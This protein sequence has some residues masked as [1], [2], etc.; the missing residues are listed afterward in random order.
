MRIYP[1]KCLRCL[2]IWSTHKYAITFILSKSGWR[3]QFQVT[4]TIL[5][6]GCS[7]PGLLSSLSYQVWIHGPCFLKLEPST[8]SN[9]VPSCSFSPKKIPVPGKFQLSAHAALSCWK[10]S[11]KSVPWHHS[12]FELQ[13]P[14]SLWPGPSPTSLGQRCADRRP[15]ESAVSLHVIWPSLPDTADL[16][17]LGFQGTVPSVCLPSLCGPL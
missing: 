4:N 15:S 14:F 2:L 6:I 5:P 7:L 11:N 16:S 10:T 8:P 12:G 13:L 3:V 1:I 17:P 9:L